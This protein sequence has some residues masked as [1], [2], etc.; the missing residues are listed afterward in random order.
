MEQQ[1]SLT[2]L[3]SKWFLCVEGAGMKVKPNYRTFWSLQQETQVS[4][5][6]SFRAPS[7]NGA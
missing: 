6:V 7:K 5:Y 2:I 1:H 3:K 4:I